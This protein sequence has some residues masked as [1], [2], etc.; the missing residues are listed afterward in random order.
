MA[1]DTFT[2]CVRTGANEQISKSVYQAKFGDGYEQVAENGINSDQ[3]TWPLT[4]SGNLEDMRP[5]RA[6]LKSHITTS[7]WW[8]NPWGETK[9]YRVKYDSVNP[10]F[11]NGNFVEISFTFV[12]A[13][14]P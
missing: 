6:F 9:L 4:C 8:E 10:N 14:S 1:T 2:W 5:V 3:E 7:F 12:Q 11:I 13:Y